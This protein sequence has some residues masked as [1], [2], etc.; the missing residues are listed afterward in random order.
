MPRNVENPRDQVIGEYQV[1]GVLGE[2]G[3][4]IVYAAVH[5]LIGKRVAIKVLR[6]ELHAPEFVDRFVQEARAVNQIGHPGI[7]DVFGFGQLPDGAHYFVMELLDGE[8][9][10][11]RMTRGRLSPAEALPILRQMASAV[12]AAHRAGIVHR[13][14]KPDNVFLVPDPDGGPPRV[15]ILDFGIAKL[16]AGAAVKTSTGV[17]MGTPLFMSPEQCRGRGVDSR[18]DVYAFG[19]IAHHMLTG[20]YPFQADSPVA[21]LYM[22]ISDPP[23]LPS[24]FGVHAAFDVV[25]GKALAKQPEERHA[26]LGAMVEAFGFTQARLEEATGRRTTGAVPAM[27][28]TR[29][30]TR[31]VTIPPAPAPATLAPM[32]AP[33]TPLPSAWVALRKLM[34]GGE[35]A[36][37]PLLGHTDKVKCVAFSPAGGLVA[38]AGA[39]KMVR[40]WDLF[41]NSLAALSG[42]RG[43]VLRLCFSPDGKTLASAGTDRFI[44]LWD[45][46]TG[47]ARATLQGHGDA[48]NHL[49]FTPDGR[50][51]LSASH[52]GT[53]RLWTLKAEASVPIVVHRAPVL[54]LACAADGRTVA[55]ASDDRTIRLADLSSGHNR[56]LEGHTG[57]VC[58]VAFAPDGDTLVSGSH[59]R[60]VRVWSVRGRAGRLL[61]GH[62][63][64]VWHVDVSPDG[65]RIA[66]AG[67]DGAVMLW[68][69]EG[70]TPIVLGGGQGA[71]WHAAFSPD[72]RLLASAGSDKTVRLWDLEGPAC[73][74]LLPTPGAARMVAF[75]PDGANL[76]VANEH[77]AVLLTRVPQPHK[78]KVP[79]VKMAT[80][81]LEVETEKPRPRGWLRGLF[82]TVR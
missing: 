60:T 72:S 37:R 81:V 20:G 32:R 38:S 71:V 62:Q 3:M 52:D 80:Q 79:S 63:G 9:L 34:S 4:G 45:V 69:I 24:A 65:K 35:G 68:R 22:Q 41:G 33:P 49:C 28:G 2:G 5:P 76:T 44:Q 43:T 13:D 51:L 17:P 23:R 57:A 74:S 58:T 66:S 61:K 31:G 11:D 73:S 10:G 8:S 48:V 82:S 18:T 78:L 12:D 6:N 64:A 21:L 36:V 47:A 54:Q 29:T 67:A 42:H 27:S 25:I 15:K 16:G 55:S 59:D 1:T 19:V 30:P 75:S 46:A 26:T 53:V 14:L 50:S 56:I 40:L 70:S 77:A 7:I 39:D